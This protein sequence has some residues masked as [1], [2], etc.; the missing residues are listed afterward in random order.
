MK[1]RSARLV[2][3]SLRLCL[4][5]TML[6]FDVPDFYI[7]LLSTDCCILP[8]CAA[9]ISINCSPSVYFGLTY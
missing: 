3:E 8:A 5:T 4:P 9:G 2:S 7:T 1:C 6:T